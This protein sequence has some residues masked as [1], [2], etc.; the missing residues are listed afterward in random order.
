MIVEEKRY[1]ETLSPFEKRRSTLLLFV[2]EKPSVA[3]EAKP[4][5]S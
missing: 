4:S 3:R 5:E 1:D 2:D